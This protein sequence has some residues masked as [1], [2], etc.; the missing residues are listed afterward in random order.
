V[1]VL[2][3]VLLLV[4]D[5]GRVMQCGW[6]EGVYKA[7]FDKMKLRVTSSQCAG[8]KFVL[9]F[10]LRC[11]SLDLGYLA[12]MTVCTSPVEVYS[13]LQYLT[14]AEE[15]GTTFILFVFLTEVS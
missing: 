13:H 7:T 6:R 4:I 2:F 3:F 12:R 14:Q 9:S 10:G 15:I 5:D 8:S 11:R 1:L